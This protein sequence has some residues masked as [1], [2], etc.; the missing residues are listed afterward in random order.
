LELSWQVFC[1]LTSMSTA[2][3]QFSNIFFLVFHTLL[4]F[5]NCFGW[6]WQRTR[7]WNL[8]TLGV[9]AF[10]WLVMGLWKG[11]GYCV[12]TD[13][14]WQIRRALGQTTNESSYLDYLVKVLS[15]WTPDPALTRTVAGLVFATSIVLS[16]GLNV[17]DARRRAA[18]PLTEVQPLL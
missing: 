2:A 3:L 10:S 5:F 1:K 6:A 17:R 12:C 16:I 8:A 13:W 7:K 15:G 11:V 4:I 9:T 18:T 14:H